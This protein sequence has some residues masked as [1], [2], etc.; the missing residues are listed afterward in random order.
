MSPV[1]RGVFQWQTDVVIPDRSWCLWCWSTNSILVSF[2]FVVPVFPRFSFFHLI[3]FWNILLAVLS[4]ARTYKYRSINL[5]PYVYVRWREGLHGTRDRNVT[6]QKC[7]GLRPCNQSSGIDIQREPKFLKFRSCYL[8]ETRNIEKHQ[9]FGLE[10][11]SHCDAMIIRVALH[12]FHLR[13]EEEAIISASTESRLR[14]ECVS[15]PPRRVNLILW[16]QWRCERGWLHAHN[17][18]SE[19]LPRLIYV[20]WYTLW[21]GRTANTTV[22]YAAWPNAAT[23]SSTSASIPATAVSTT[24]SISAAQI[25]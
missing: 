8:P 6:V 25:F 12:H 14:W 19:W 9:S 18:G 20:S 2:F 5:C 7:N 10:V 15:D 3:I 4:E 17:Y 22:Q 24:A 1:Y 11:I 13:Y 16:I 23:A 21:I